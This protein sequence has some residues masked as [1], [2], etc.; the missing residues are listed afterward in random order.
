MVSLSNQQFKEL[1][2]FVEATQLQ[3]DGIKS[4]IV[5]A[6]QQGTNLVFDESNYPSR[7]MTKKELATLL[8]ISPRHFAN[9]TKMLRPH[10]RDMGVTDRARLLPPKAVKFIC[11]AMGIEK[12]EDLNCNNLHAP[13]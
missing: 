8:K 9:Q 7:P 5:K 1:Q 10:L 4:L 3:L 12:N 6:K 11:E 2:A 13:T